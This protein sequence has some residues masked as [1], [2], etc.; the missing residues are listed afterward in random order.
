MARP[1]HPVEAKV[2]SVIGFV[3]VMAAG[4]A[5]GRAP[6]PMLVI[7]LGVSTGIRLAGLWLC[8][9]GNPAG[10]DVEPDELAA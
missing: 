3:V 8:V 10:A 9:D 6:T 1:A 2:L 7:A 5:M 4:I